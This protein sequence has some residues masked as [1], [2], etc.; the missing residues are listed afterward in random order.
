MTDLNNEIGAAPRRAIS[1][2]IPV[3]DGNFRQAPERFKVE[4]S[5]ES[6]FHFFRSPRSMI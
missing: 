2:P 4:S 3:S 6:I 1:Y 5:R